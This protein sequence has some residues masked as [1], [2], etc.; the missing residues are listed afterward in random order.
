MIRAPSRY[1]IPFIV[2][3]GK[4]F[5]EIAATNSSLLN[6][7]GLGKMYDRYTADELFFGDSLGAPLPSFDEPR[8]APE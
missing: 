8:N 1:A 3:T 6:Q 2:S 5:S 4:P 7:E